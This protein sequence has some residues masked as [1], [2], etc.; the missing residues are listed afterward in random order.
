MIKDCL[1]NTYRH[2]SWIELGESWNSQPDDILSVA[3]YYTG[4]IR[5]SYRHALRAFELNPDDKRIAKNLKIIS[6]KLC[7]EVRHGAKI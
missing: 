6:L 7:E 4:D 3:Y 2:Y 1:R 5:K